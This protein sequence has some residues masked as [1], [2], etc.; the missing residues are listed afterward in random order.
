MHG[1]NKELDPG[2]LWHNLMENIPLLLLLS[3]TPNLAIYRLLIYCKHYI[4]QR[5]NS[6]DIHH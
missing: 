2:I 4:N 6:V 5:Y 3:E 1:L